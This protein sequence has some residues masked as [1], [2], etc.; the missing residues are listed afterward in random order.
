MPLIA[1]N[2]PHEATAQL[3]AI[4]EYVNTYISFYPPLSDEVLYRA[5]CGETFARAALWLPN[6]T[7]LS[8]FEQTLSS[9]GSRE[10]CRGSDVI[11]P[12][13]EGGGGGDATRD[14]RSLKARGARDALDHVV[15]HVR[16][17]AQLM[18]LPSP[19]EWIPVHV[20]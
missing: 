14:E 7:S 11:M 19:A 1:L 4:H 8:P 18:Y 20:L 6:A 5:P 17:R 13:G 10:G 12:P 2:I 16:L 3:G 9:A 15:Y